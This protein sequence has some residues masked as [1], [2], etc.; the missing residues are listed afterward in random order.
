MGLVTINPED[1]HE[2]PLDGITQGTFSIKS[3]VF[4]FNRSHRLSDDFKASHQM[5]VAMEP[6][7]AVT[8][9]GGHEGRNGRRGLTRRLF[10]QR[11]GRRLT[12]RIQKICEHGEEFGWKNFI[13]KIVKIDDILLGSRHR[14]SRE[15]AAAKRPQE[16]LP[17]GLGCS[18]T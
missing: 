1:T 2:L 12:R 3:R 5:F 15:S 9:G 8:I 16:E 13:L 6:N 7:G 4:E 10:S 14:D 11:G 18:I 17:K